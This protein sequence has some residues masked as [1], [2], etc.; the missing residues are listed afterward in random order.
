MKS[1][2]CVFWFQYPN[3][4][5]R[6]VWCRGK[7]STAILHRSSEYSLSL[8]GD[9][10]DV[11][12]LDEWYDVSPQCTCWYCCCK[13]LVVHVTRYAKVLIQEF[14]VKVDQGFLPSLLLLR[15]VSDT[16]PSYIKYWVFN[17]QTCNVEYS[18]NPWWKAEN[19]CFDFST[20]T[21][22]RDQFDAEEKWAQQYCTDQVSTL[23]HCSGIVWM[24]TV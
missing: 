21:L 17:S 3:P 7:M 20:Q 14:A 23:Y 24:F 9:S 8:L 18:M 10:L 1:W 22:H 12:S 2:E 5:Q 13:V 16:I 6:S 11:Y 19:V 4:S 15:V